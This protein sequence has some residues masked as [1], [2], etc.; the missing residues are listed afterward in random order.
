MFL[1]NSWNGAKMRARINT[2]E[3]ETVVTRELGKICLDLVYG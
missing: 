1:G 2:A 3:N